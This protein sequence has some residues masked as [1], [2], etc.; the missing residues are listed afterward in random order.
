VARGHYHGLIKP[1]CSGHTARK[2]LQRFFR[3]VELREWVW[4]PRGGDPPLL[5][6]ASDYVM[7]EPM[8]SPST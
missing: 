1:W 6:L 5:I 8:F 3:R 2:L 7:T 4:L